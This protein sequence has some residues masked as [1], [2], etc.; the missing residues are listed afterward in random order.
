[1]ISRY[2]T[3][4]FS[5]A[6]AVETWDTW[7]RW[8][9]GGQLRDLSIEATWLRV[10][11][12]L[13]AVEA[14]EP[15]RWLQRFMDAQVDWRLLFDESILAS[16]GTDHAD[17]PQT[18]TAVLNAAQF[19]SAPFAPDACFDFAG[20]GHVAKL[21]VR[22][23]DNALLAQSGRSRTSKIRVGMIG[24][25]D[26]LAFLGKD[27]DS[28][29]ARAGAE[30]MARTLA[31]ACLYA[32]S[33]LARE[34]GPCSAGSDALLE[35]YERRG[36]PAELIADASRRGLRHAS[37][38]AIT[39]QRRLA[40]LANN[41]A[42]ALDPVAGNTGTPLSRSRGYALA[43]ARQHTTEASARRLSSKTPA[44]SIAA[45]VEMRS[46][47]QPWMDIPIDYPFRKP[48]VSSA[49]TALHC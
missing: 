11:E 1:M 45:Q 26:A 38:T 43:L 10:A 30:S 35:A 25:A 20:F 24:V 18:P 27:Y 4:P 22:G 41:V 39:S 44:V 29:D 36:A 3:S 6:V 32:S 33:H 7:F 12:A 21:A 8:R 13:A 31:E 37:L 14:T 5:D 15:A 17:W 48:D 28:I 46:A 47:V 49:C 23:L 42:D 19:V 9:N 40:L 2:A 16:A 34:R